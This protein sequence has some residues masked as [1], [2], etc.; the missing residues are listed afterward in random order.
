M[1]IEFFAKVQ[2]EVGYRACGYLWLHTQERLQQALQSRERQLDLGWPVE[3]WTLS[4]LGR[5]IPFLDKAHGIAGAI[6][7]P[8]DGLVNPNLVKNYYRSEARKRGVLFEDRSLLRNVEYD[9]SGVDRIRVEVD[10]FEPALSHEV[11]QQVLTCS[12]SC[13]SG[14]A[15]G[16]KISGVSYEARRMINCAGPWASEVARILGYKVI[17]PDATPDLFI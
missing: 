10:H 8:R 11:K 7:S 6:Y 15:R 4:E 3:V 5:R 2:E 9:R 1:T 17:I 13:A 16:V 12:T 14:P